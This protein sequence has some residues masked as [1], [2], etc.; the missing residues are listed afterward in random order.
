MISSQHH[1]LSLYV[2]R[3]RNS[4]H[5][6]QDILQR[7]DSLSKNHDIATIDKAKNIY[8]ELLKRYDPV[9]SNRQNKKSD[10]IR[11]HPNILRASSGLGE[12]N[13]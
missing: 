9:V 13:I 3:A 11:D 8:F 5:V 2:S 12:K 1:R 7:D 10:V 6:K 4:H